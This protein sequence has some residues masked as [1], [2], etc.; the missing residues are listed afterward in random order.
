MPAIHLARLKIQIS[1]L[2]SF[3]D[4]PSDFIRELHEIFE[5]YADRT[6]RP[7]Q[8][9]KPKPL[10]QAYNVP[11]QVMRRL[12]S[13]IAS[14]VVDDPEGGIDLADR[15]WVDSWFEC[16]L[17]AINILGCLP[18]MHHD[19]VVARL[20]R[21]GGSCKEDMLIDTLLQDGAS[22]LD[23]KSNILR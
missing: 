16:R 17:L 9:G 3:Y 7:G 15:L 8:S 18:I 19:Q 22:I 1:E 13:D 20:S 21:W 6:R 5:F 10:I 4:S 11:R 12:Y 23:I 2:L 14:L